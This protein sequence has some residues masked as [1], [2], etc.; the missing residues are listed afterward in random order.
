MKFVE[1]LQ[2][3]TN[4][5][6]K[7]THM[8]ELI[9]YFC[10]HNKI[11]VLKDTLKNQFSCWKCKK[12]VQ[13]NHKRAHDDLCQKVDVQ[14]LLSLIIHVITMSC[15]K[16]KIPQWKNGGKWRRTKIIYIISAYGEIAFFVRLAKYCVCSCVLYGFEFFIN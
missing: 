12:K 16:R 8:K 7:T 6:L 10:R 1:I 4:R 11:N 5:N 9:A 2:K 13:Q 3:E 15:L 14:F